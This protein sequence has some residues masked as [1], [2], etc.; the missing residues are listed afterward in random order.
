[1][2]FIRIVERKTET[3]PKQFFSKQETS[4]F[5]LVDLRMTWLEC[6]FLFPMKILKESLRVRENKTI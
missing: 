1:M 3:M 6:Q 4:L 2:C 5:C